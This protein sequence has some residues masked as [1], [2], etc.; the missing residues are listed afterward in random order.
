M[1]DRTT[2]TLTFLPEGYEKAKELNQEVEGNEE[3]YYSDPENIEL[4]EVF[5]HGVNGGNLDFEKVLQE[6]KIPYDK[7]WEPHPNFAGGCEYVRVDSDGE[8]ITKEFYD[9][10]E[11]VVPLATLIEVRKGG[12]EAVDA[13][14]TTTLE[15]QA[16][17]S[18]SEQVAILLVR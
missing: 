4:V 15:E 16:V 3:T 17:L 13:F 9:G 10:T 12:L 14:I 2:V 5:Y 7:R 8:I 18:W 1:G 6:E 11:G